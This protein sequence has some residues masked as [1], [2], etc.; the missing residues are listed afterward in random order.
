[1]SF[2]LNLGNIIKQ[3]VSQRSTLEAK[4]NQMSTNITEVLSEVA[5]IDKGVTALLNKTTTDSVTIA[6]LQETN[7]ALT[8]HNA[9]LVQQVSDLTTKQAADDAEDAAADTN[10]ETIK[11]SLDTITAKLPVEP[12]PVE[13]TPIP[14]PVSNSVFQ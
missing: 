12:V 10:L 11:A 7:T 14:A 8:A 1:M 6:T 4:V 2:F 13:P 5:N 9:T 3:F